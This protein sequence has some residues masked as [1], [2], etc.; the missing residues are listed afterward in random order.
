MAYEKVDLDRI[1]CWNFIS[2]YF[3]NADL[4]SSHPRSQLEPQLEPQTLRRPPEMVGV[5][6]SAMECR[7]LRCQVHFVQRQRGLCHSA[8]HLGRPKFPAALVGL[9]TGGPW[10]GVGRRGAK[11]R[12]EMNQRKDTKRTNEVEE[13]FLRSE[14]SHSV[15]EHSFFV[16][17]LGF[18]QNCQA[19]LLR[20]RWLLQACWILLKS[21][22]TEGVE[23]CGEMWRVE[24][25]GQARRGEECSAYLCSKTAKINTDHLGV[26]SRGSGRSLEGGASGW[27]R[28]FVRHVFMILHTE[29]LRLNKDG[30]HSLAFAVSLFDV[31][32]HALL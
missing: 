25:P 5:P 9:Q 24:K 1:G 22:S 29:I 27:K 10:D 2:T 15:S 19:Q 23:R 3:N 4:L 31:A 12:L 6:W 17:F 30:L 8:G 32:L 20:L 16:I 26:S 21:K 18:L 14:V 11:N 13:F 28:T 7:C